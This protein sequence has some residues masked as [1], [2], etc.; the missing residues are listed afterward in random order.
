MKCRWFLLFIIVFVGCSEAKKTDDDSKQSGT[1]VKTEGPNLDGH[2]VVESMES[3][4]NEVPESIY[5]DM[6]W[7]IEGKKITMNKGQHENVST[8][9]L[10][11]ETHPKQIDLVNYDDGQQ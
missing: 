4:G 5:K 6:N 2:W 7:N 9:S 3:D 1:E 11:L 10:N 8:F